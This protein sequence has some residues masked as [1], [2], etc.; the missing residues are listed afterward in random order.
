MGDDLCIIGYQNLTELYLLFFVVFTGAK[1]S[2][3]SS[4]SA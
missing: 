4:T 3:S 1:T 2:F